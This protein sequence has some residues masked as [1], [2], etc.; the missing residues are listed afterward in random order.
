MRYATFGSVVLVALLAACG[1]S[2][3]SMPKG[4][5]F[6]ADAA[7]GAK[8]D[9]A[10][11]PFHLH[12]GIQTSRRAVIDNESDW[13]TTWGELTKPSLVPPNPPIIDF[14]KYMVV[15]VAS[16]SK[17]TGGYCIDIT[18]VAGFPDGLYVLFT[19]TQPSPEWVESQAVTQPTDLKLVLRTSEPVIFE[20][21]RH[22]AQCR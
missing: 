12:S 8:F 6:D 15:L 3:A 13:R 22:T 16:G 19:E 4:T 17:P 7:A 2:D 5:P 9:S 18:A 1:A 20:G 11:A 14:D 21:D 10:I